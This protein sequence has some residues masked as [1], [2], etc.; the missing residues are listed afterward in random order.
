MTHDLKGLSPAYFGMVMATG[1]IS[2]TAHFLGF[3]LVAHSLFYL[4]LCFYGVLWIATIARFLIYRREFLL[5]VIDHL[6]GPGFSPCPP[7]LA[8]L[9]VSL[10]R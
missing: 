8:C 7:A 10:L 2:L 6:R 4:N 1:I 5:D 3:D 9:A